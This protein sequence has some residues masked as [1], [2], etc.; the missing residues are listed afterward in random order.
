MDVFKKLVRATLPTQ[1]CLLCLARS[2]QESPIC[3]ACMAD[4]PYIDQRCSQCGLPLALG[5]ASCGHCQNDPP[6]FASCHCLLQYQHPVDYLITQYK[7]HR[8]QPI[9]RWW[10]QQVCQAALQLEGNWD[11]LIPVPLHWRKQW[12]RG[13]NQSFEI[14]ETLASALGV[15]IGNASRTTPA[16]AQKQLSRAQ[17]LANFSHSFSVKQD[18]ANLRILV[19]DDVV[20]TGATAN[21]LAKRL[22]KLGALRVDVFA[23]ARTPKPKDKHHLRQ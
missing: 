17:R 16:Q 18:V 20:T 8:H 13:F 5:S 6:V 14:A 19:V 23:L 1:P 21:A 3:L 2:S 10:Q 9:R 12:R 4:L 11:L 15:T 22:I 7:E